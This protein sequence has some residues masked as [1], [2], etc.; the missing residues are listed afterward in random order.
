MSQTSQT[1]AFNKPTPPDL[2]LLLVNVNELGNFEFSEF[3]VRAYQVQAKLVRASSLS[4]LIN[5]LI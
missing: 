2:N 3:G 5:N 4:N 1:L